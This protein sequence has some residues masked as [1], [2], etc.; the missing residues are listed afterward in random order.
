MKWNKLGRIFDPT[1]VENRDWCKEFAQCTS[2]LIFDNFVRVYFSCRPKRDKDGNCVSYTAFVDLDRNNLFKIIRIADKP[3]LEL[4]DLGTFD[5]FGVYPTCV[6]K[7]ADKIYLFYAGWTRCVST[8]AN[9][10]I[11]VAISHD[12]G[13]TF[14]RLGKG[15]ILTRSLYEPFVISGPKVRT[16][17]KALGLYM[18]YLAGEKW[19][20]SNG[21]SEVIYK[22]RL[23]SSNVGD[24]INWEKENVNI[25]PSILGEDECQAGPDV[26]FHNDR[27]HMYFSYR[28]GLDF[29]KNN[30]GYRIGYAYSE[31]LLNWVRDDENVGIKLSDDGWDSQDMHYPHIFELN[32]EHYMLYNG[33]EF[34][35]YGFG[36]AIL[37][38]EK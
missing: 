12:D 27:Y 26:F 30:R 2:T 38:K 35:K 31:D 15:P 36:L 33:N 32:G 9:V 13:V 18:Y 37:E 8:F 6:N 19:V 28:Y 4:G 5:E 10:S 16:F 7:L 21:R 20:M 22:I 14:K 3:I 23:A 25:I 29:R 34:G 17:P 24:G 1:K 11:G